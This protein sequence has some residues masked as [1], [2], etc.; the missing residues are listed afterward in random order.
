MNIFQKAALQGLIKNRARTMVTIVGVILS[1]ALVTGAATFAASLQSYM[2]RGAELHYGGWHVEIVDADAAFAEEQKENAKIVDVCGMQNIGYALLEGGQ[3]PDKPYLFVTGWDDKM[4]DTVPVRLLSGRLPENGDEVVV[5]AHI[6]SNGGVTLLPGDTVTLMVGCRMCEKQRLSQHD[7]YRGG[8]EEIANASERTYKVVGICQRPAFEEYAA[9]GYTVITREENVTESCTV[10]VTLKTPY[11]TPAYVKSVS[12]AHGAVLNDAVLRF[13]GLSESRTLTLLLFSAVTILIV[14]VMAGSV[15]LIYNSFQISLRE[16]MYQFGILMFVGATEEQLRSTVLFEGLCIGAVGIPIGVLIGIPGIRFVLAL[17]EANFANVLYR[18]VPLSMELSPL[19]LIA[20]VLVSLTAI[21]ISAYLPARRAASVPIMECIRQT[22]ELRTD[23]GPARLLGLV[24][25]LGGQEGMLAYKNFRRSRG[26]GRSIILSLTLSVVL[27][28]S[29]SSFVAYLDQILT[30]AP[31]E[32]GTGNGSFTTRE[33]E[34]DEVRSMVFI[35]KLFSAVFVALISLIAVVNV[36]NTISASIRLRR[37]E[38][39]M[40]RSVGMSDRD[41]D[42]MMRFE[43]VLYGVQAILWSLPVSAAV[44]ALICFGLDTGQGRMT[45][46]FPWESMGLSIL[47][48]FFVV[49]ITVL[50]V[51]DKLRKEN[52]MDALRDDIA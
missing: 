4:F 42:R 2:I 8:K 28:V 25:R 20:A 37:R 24:E 34:E 9:P 17:T 48:V 14:L 33:M 51:T 46:V 36:C 27:A 21:L 1:A 26:R 49:S 38:L 39:A 16:R 3:N 31:T 40:L 7:P 32:A 44:S 15:C 30:L 35:A 12:D 19:A 10:F 50:Y 29:A 45:Y 52:I 47:G 6:A 18:D 23:A 43:C 22:A 11:Q 13:M 41:F 5:S